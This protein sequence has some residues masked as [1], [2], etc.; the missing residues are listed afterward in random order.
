MRLAT[1]RDGGAEIAAVV[2]GEAV[3]PVSRINELRGT[4]LRTNLLE[5]LQYGQVPE[6][7]DQL[8]GRPEKETRRLFAGAASRRRVAYAPPYRRP[9]KIWGI[10][11]NY[12][13]HASDLGETSPIGEPASFMKPDTTIIGVGERIRLPRQSQRTTAE[14]ELGLIVGRRAKDVAE[15]DAPSV[16]AGFTTVLDMTAEDILEKNP[17]FLTRAKSFDTFFSFGP[18]VVTPDEVGR[19]KDLEVSTV[20][21]GRR[22]R[23]NVVSNMMFSPWFL[24]SFHSKVMTLL[25]G[26]VIPTGTPGAVEIRDGDTVACEI[27]GFE[28]LYNPVEEEKVPNTGPQP[29]SA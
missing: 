23:T 29:H 24:V 18:Q 16:I 4:A 11:L 5:L 13:A 26:D 3:L 15:E 27:D 7:R 19:V 28:T 21:N 12:A 22:H 1:I 2:A 10:G 8:T 17:R 20:I 25:P 9:R 6:L 14:A